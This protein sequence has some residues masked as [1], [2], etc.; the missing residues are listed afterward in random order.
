VIDCCVILH[1]LLLDANDDV[2]QAWLDD[3]SDDASDIGE[4][5][6]EYEFA[7]NV[8]DNNSDERRQYILDYFWDQRLV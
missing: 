5:V 8:R 1:N 6:G 2:P 4:A 3:L 7:G